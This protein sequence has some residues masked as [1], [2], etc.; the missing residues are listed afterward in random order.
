MEAE[1]IISDTFLIV[2]ENRKSLPD[3]GNFDSYIY[4]VARNRAVSLYRMQHM[5]KVDLDEDEIDLF[6]QA[7]TTPEEELIAKEDVERLN[8]AINSL[9]NKCK[10]VFKLVREERLKYKEVASILEISVKTVEAHL[11]TAVK[12]LRETLIMP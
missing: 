5:K 11:A 10:L 7:D 3:I 2:W 9:P 12:K 4:S 1:E 6:F 8:R